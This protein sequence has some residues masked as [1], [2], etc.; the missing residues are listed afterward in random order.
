M[1]I[2]IIYYLLT[3]VYV[4]K[5]DGPMEV[6]WHLWDITDKLPWQLV[7]NGW[8]IPKDAGGKF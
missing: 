4:G 5:I 8:V 7:F 6:L 1:H 3:G 2:I